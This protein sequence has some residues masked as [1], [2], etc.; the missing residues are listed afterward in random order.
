M[1]WL[2]AALAQEEALPELVPPVL[3]DVPATPWPEGQPYEASSV[4]LALLIDEQGR[5]E[6]ATVLAGEE[7]FASLALKTAPGLLF[8]PAL[9]GEEPIAVEG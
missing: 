5:V 4:T 1:I 7:P 6:E 9:E 3:V 8:Q 2:A